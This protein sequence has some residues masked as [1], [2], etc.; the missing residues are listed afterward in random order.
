MSFI[1]PEYVWLLAKQS[2]TGLQLVVLL[3]SGSS[4]QLKLRTNMDN[5]MIRNIVDI[6]YNHLA[7]ANV[8]SIYVNHHKR[9]VLVLVVD[10]LVLHAFDCFW[11]LLGMS[12]K[13]MVHVLVADHLS[14]IHM[15]ISSNLRPDLNLTSLPLYW[16][17]CHNVFKCD[18]RL[19]RAKNLK[20]HTNRSTKHAKKTDIFHN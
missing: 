11:D 17:W 15:C 20:Q 9:Q 4:G 3:K 14:P 12:C 19:S 7:S 16:S 10:H 1:S 6:W 5:E 13:N 2:G 18:A 8:Y